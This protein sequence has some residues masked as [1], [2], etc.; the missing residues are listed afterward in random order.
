MSA[1]WSGMALNVGWVEPLRDPTNGNL[2]IVGSRKARPNLR[3]THGRSF[4]PR[5][6]R[7][8]ELA[9]TGFGLA[10]RFLARLE[11]ERL[12][13]VVDG[14]VDPAERSRHVGAHEVGLGA[15]GRERDRPI[16][17]APGGAEIAFPLPQ[18]G[19]VLVGERL[20]GI[21]ADRLGVVGE[22]AVEIARSL[23]DLAA[24]GER[25]R[26]GRAETDRL[27]VVGDGAGERPCPALE[28]ARDLRTLPQR[29]AVIGDGAPRLALGQVAV[30]AIDVS[31]KIFGIDADGLARVRDRAV[32]VALDVPGERA[33]VVGTGIGRSEPDRRV[34]V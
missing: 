28:R 33:V 13:V 1:R 24:L 14:V 18:T 25:D 8:R 26:I 12:L 17:V 10:P 20:A 4:V 30:A 31:A 3:I 11:L 5:G 7:T 9:D 27:G 34:V 16:G 23:P 22:R 19:A 21:E 32:V 2:P 6:D 29:L 15:L